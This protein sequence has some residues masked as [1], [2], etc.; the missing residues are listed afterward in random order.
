MTAG[1]VSLVCARTDL[2]VALGADASAEVRQ[3]ARDAVR[4]NCSMDDL[5]GVLTTN[6]LS[7]TPS[8]VAAEV[9]SD[10]PGDLRVLVRGELT[11]ELRYGDGTT[12]TLAAGRSATWKDDVLAG[13]VEVVVPDASTPVAV[14]VPPSSDVADRAVV[15]PPQAAAEVVAA[16]PVIDELADDGPADDLVA[17]TTSMVPRS[18]DDPVLAPGGSGEEGAD[19]AR[20]R[21]GPPAGSD[22]VLE[23]LDD[24]PNVERSTPGHDAGDE[25]S[26]P[27]EM[28]EEDTEDPADDPYLS[29]LLEHTVFHDVEDAARRSSDDDDGRDDAL[30][31]TEDPGSDEHSDVD[32]I[33][34][35]ADDPA[36]LHEL[37]EDAGFEAEDTAHV[38]Q[39]EAPGTT[40][41]DGVISAIPGLAPPPASGGPTGHMDSTPQVPGAPT[42]AVVDDDE[43]I[44]DGLGDHDGRTVSIGDAVAATSAADTPTPDAPGVLSRE[45]PAGHLSPPT[46]AACRICGVDISETR[47]GTA[48]MPVVAQLRFECGPLVDLDRTQV[49]GRQPTAEGFEVDGEIPGLVPLASPDGKLSR[50]HVAVRLEDWS[51]LVEDLGSTN[52]TEVELPGQDRERIREFNPRMVVP[53]TTVILGENERFHIEVPQ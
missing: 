19:D 27:D 37:P 46:D 7:A 43:F 25:L 15:D 18:T 30:E 36:T 2:F 53:G 51:I 44:G 50:R 38:A 20:D 21:N 16:V 22:G 13:A 5:L 17:A 29:N 42:P 24:D 8:F 48:I 11:L 31:A 1:D 26:G 12:D 14:W 10:D 47:V 45:C 6:G 52:G 28:P 40:P 4:S 32:D 39:D 33:V 41:S 35:G 23:S 9:A 3:A 34:V 49:I